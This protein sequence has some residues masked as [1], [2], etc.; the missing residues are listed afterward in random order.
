MGIS[1]LSIVDALRT[2]SVA[3]SSYC[4]CQD[5]AH[6]DESRQVCS[7]REPHASVTWSLQL[8]NIF[9]KSRLSYFTCMWNIMLLLGAL[10]L[11]RYLGLSFFLCIKFA[12]AKIC[13]CSLWF[14][15][16]K[17]KS[18]PWTD[19]VTPSA[20]LGQC[21]LVTPTCEYFSKSRLSYFTC[22]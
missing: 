7:I 11:R 3:T 19:G 13:C 14:A 17:I 20:K 8:A 10:Y 12:C 21:D 6:V 15:R 18:F 5:T 9:L 1:L 22:M 4:E 16:A 2:D